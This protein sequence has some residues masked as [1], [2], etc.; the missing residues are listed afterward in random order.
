MTY[1]IIDPALEMSS[2]NTITMNTALLPRIPLE[3]EDTKPPSMKTRMV[4]SL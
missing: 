1:V 4:F 2:R 3:I